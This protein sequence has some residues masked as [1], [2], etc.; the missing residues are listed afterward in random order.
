[1]DAAPLDGFVAE[2]GGRPVGLL[3][4]ADAGE[5]VEVVTIHVEAEGRGA[6]RAL[7]DAIRARAESVGACRL[8]LSTTNDN[9]RAIAFYQRW[10]MDLVELRHDAVARSRAVKPSI[11]LVSDGIP[12]R[13]ELVFEVRLR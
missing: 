2:D 7:M 12:V 3:T 11:P 10:G 1:M 4:Y 8:W 5:E 13:H 9:V 6:G